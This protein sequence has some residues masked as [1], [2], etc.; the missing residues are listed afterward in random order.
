MVHVKPL[1]VLPLTDAIRL[2]LKVQAAVDM[3]D[4]FLQATYILPMECDE[5]DGRPQ[6]VQRPLTPK[7][8]AAYHAA[9][10]FLECYMDEPHNC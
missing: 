7:E 1:T 9:L 4:A 2:Q 10:N 3:V 8:S 6:G 5:I